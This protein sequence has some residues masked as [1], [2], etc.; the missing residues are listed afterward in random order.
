MFHKTLV[1]QQSRIVSSWLWHHP[2][3][4]GQR[5]QREPDHDAYGRDDRKHSQRLVTVRIVDAKRLEQTPHA[6]V[7]MEAKTP[8]HQDIKQ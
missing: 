2:R 7:K 6:V 5:H 3:H 4:E 1:T 8:H